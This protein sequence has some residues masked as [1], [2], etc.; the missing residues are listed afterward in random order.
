MD[1]LERRLA[2]RLV[3]GPRREE[4]GQ[5]LAGA[6]RHRLAEAGVELQALVLERSGLAGGAW[7]R[8][9]HDDQA[10]QAQGAARGRGC[11]DGVW[12]SS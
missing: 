7:L 4:E 1:E 10:A 8:V 3:A 12:F 5:R 6:D 9:A 2:R 11:R